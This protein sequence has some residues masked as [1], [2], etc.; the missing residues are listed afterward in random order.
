LALA[1][2]DGLAVVLGEAAPDAVRLADG[3]RVRPALLQDGAG[4]AD[5]A[6]GGVALAARGAALALRVEEQP[7]VGVAARALQ[8]PLPDVSNRSGES[9]DLG[10]VHH[11]AVRPGEMPRPDLTSNR[12][13]VRARTAVEGLGRR[14]SLTSNQL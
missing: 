4:G 6:G 11:L 1:G 7:R 5:V 2:V 9:G 3:Q 8:L 13:A 14:I 12:S 10:H